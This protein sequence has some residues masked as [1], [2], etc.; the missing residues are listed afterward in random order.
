[1]SSHEPNA[2]P[3]RAPGPDAPAAAPE[4]PRDVAVSRGEPRSGVGR[5]LGRAVSRTTRVFT[6]FVLSV[7]LAAATLVGL[8]YLT[9]DVADPG[10]LS[11]ITARTQTASFTVA[12]P[13]QSSFYVDGFRLFSPGEPWNG[14]CAEDALGP[15]WAVEPQ[16]GTRL[17]YDVIDKD[18]I[19]IEIR[20]IDFD[21]EAE[22]AVLRGLAPD[23]TPRSVSV[24]GDMALRADV[25]CRGARTTRLP[26]WGPGEIGDL[27]TFRVEGPTPTLLDGEV[28]IYGRSAEGGS[29]PLVRWLRESVLGEKFTGERPLY[30]SLSN[31]FKIP[32]GSRVTTELGEADQSLK[33]L[34]GFAIIDKDSSEAVVMSVNVSTEAPTLFIY[35]PGS[36]GREPDRLEMSQLSQLTNDPNLQFLLQLIIAFAV[37]L[38]ITM[39]AVRPL[40]ARS[41]EDW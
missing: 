31:A 13:G 12:N 8:M 1:M 35:S 21:S 14:E 17:R 29:L 28:E 3:G 15:N 22:R 4:R 26:I 6:R 34:R 7:L 32:P 5:L 37:I 23:D 11:V 10:A 19:Y 2:E 33:A 40:F 18:R 16:L 9:R 24:G 39:E 38:P 36:S 27:P 41:D 30:A 25:S 20:A